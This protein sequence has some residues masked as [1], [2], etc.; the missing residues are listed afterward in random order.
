[1]EENFLDKECEQTKKDIIYTRN[2]HPTSS[3]GAEKWT[4]KWNA[5]LKHIEKCIPCKDYFT[6]IRRDGVN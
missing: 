6:E 2:H 4:P 3:D 1:M 5:I